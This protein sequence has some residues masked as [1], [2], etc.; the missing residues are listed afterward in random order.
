MHN[1]TNCIIIASYPSSPSSHSSALGIPPDFVHHIILALLPHPL[2]V[3]KQPTYS[4]YTQGW[5]IIILFSITQYSNVKVEYECPYD[6]SWIF[7]ILLLVPLTP[8]IAEHGCAYSHWS[9]IWRMKQCMSKSQS[10]SL[11][12]NACPSKEIEGCIY[13][14]SKGNR[15][16]IYIYICHIRTHLSETLKET[17]SDA[18]TVRTKFWRSFINK[19]DT[20]ITEPTWTSY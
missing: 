16:C 5:V 12:V 17:L 10:G 4:S 11:V 2:H 14:N 19:E 7:H 8:C 20:I 9:H 6:Q 13:N 3:F 15:A 18:N 1:I